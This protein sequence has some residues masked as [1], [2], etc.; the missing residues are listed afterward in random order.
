MLDGAK[1]VDTM[2]LVLVMLLAKEATLKGLTHNLH[3]MTS[4][5]WLDVEADQDGLDRYAKQAI[6]DSVQP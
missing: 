2:G 3:L 4:C 5:G 1:R 6:F